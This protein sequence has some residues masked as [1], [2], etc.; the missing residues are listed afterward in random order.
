VLEAITWR[1][2][3]GPLKIFRKYSEWLREFCLLR[4]NNG[5]V[6]AA[7]R[8]ATRNRQA[9][10]DFEG[11]KARRLQAAAMFARGKRQTDAAAALGVSAQTASR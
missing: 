7:T 8:S 1:A 4:Y 2:I 3:G 5:D 11:L 9:R 6:P 10:R